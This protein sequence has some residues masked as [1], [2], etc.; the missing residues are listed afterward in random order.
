MINTHQFITFYLERH[1]S[2][3]FYRLCHVREL[4]I[5]QLQEPELQQFLP[6]TY[7]SISSI[8]KVSCVQP[9]WLEYVHRSINNDAT[10]T[11]QGG[12]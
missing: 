7:H 12:I 3:C 9:L 11:I 4:A 8:S 1:I 5:I 2:S 6:Q 10:E